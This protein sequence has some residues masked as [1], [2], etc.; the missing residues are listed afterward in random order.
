MLR[1]KMKTPAALQWTSF[2]GDV[3]SKSMM[4]QDRSEKFYRAIGVG[5]AEKH[6]VRNSARVEERAPASQVAAGLGRHDCVNVSDQL[7]Y[8][9][10]RR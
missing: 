5:R 8:L 4:L 1:R 6:S 3:W 7:V 10:H 9:H 2:G